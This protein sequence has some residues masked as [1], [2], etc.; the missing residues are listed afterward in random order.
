MPV[1][2]NFSY[3]IHQ[4]DI[5]FPDFIL[6]MGERESIMAG[7]QLANT[8]DILKCIYYIINGKLSL[9]AMSSDGKEKKCMFIIR[10]MFYGEAHLYDNFPTIFRVVAEVPTTY[11][12]IPLR[13]ARNLIDTSP[14][15]RTLFIN[16]QAQKIRCMT[17]ELVSLLIHKPEERGLHYIIDPI[18][19]IKEKD[20]TKCIKTSQQTIADALGMHRVTVATALSVLKNSGFIS[21]KRNEIT[22]IKEPA[23]CADRWPALTC[24]S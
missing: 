14:E 16:A 8:G 18:E 24:S 2:F 5:V 22:L 6:K 1:D 10:N 13:T 20:D 7:N 4:D 9:N 12:K 21:C 19:H 17:G 15:F 11:I 23:Y 3:F